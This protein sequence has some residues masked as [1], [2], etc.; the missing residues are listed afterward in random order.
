MPGRRRPHRR[1]HRA[2]RDQGHG[3]RRAARAREDAPAVRAPRPP[4]CVRVARPVL[5]RHRRAGAPPRGR[6]HR[7]RRRRPRGA[8]GALGLPF[9]LAI[10]FGELDGTFPNHPPT[11]STWR[12]SRTSRPR[13]SGATPTSASRSTATPT[14]WC[15]STTGASR[16]RV[17][18]PPPSSPPGSSTAPGRGGGAQPDLLEGGARGRSA[19][20]AAR[21]SAAGSA[22]RSSSRSWPRPARCSAASTRRT[23]TSATTT[24]PTRDHRRAHGARA[25]REAG[26]PLS[27]LRAALRALRRGRARST[28]GSPS[29]RRSSSGSQP[30]V[31]D[32]RA[33][34]PRRPHRRPR[35]LVV[36]PPAEQHRAAAPP[37][38][39]GGRPRR[40]RPAHRRSA[41]PGHPRGTRRRHGARSQA[42]RDPRLPRGQGPAPLLRGRVVALQPAAS[43]A[44]RGAGRHPHHADRRGGRRSTTPSTSGSSPRP[45]A[46]GIAP[47]FE[48]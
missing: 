23:T 48:A 25:A 31:R 7:Q 45:D 47:T 41:R 6:R 44:L 17:P 40:V 30:S 24:A 42:A 20:R 32:G 46:D 33:G 8:G 11:R 9:D 18:P 5:R 38:P 14:A 2:G 22:T 43:S 16:S 35:R 39:R 4:A 19:S 1:G 28:P 36:Q 26:V 34:P 37:Q 21:R 13:W 12:T 10:L 15:S 3:G 27:E 29:P